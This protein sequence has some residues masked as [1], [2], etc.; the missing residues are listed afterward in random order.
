MLL[1]I[2]YRLS[3]LML[4]LF[5]AVTSVSI[6]ASEDAGQTVPAVTQD[7]QN[8]QASPNESADIS[9]RFE[10][11]DKIHFAP[12]PENPSLECGTINLPVDYRKPRGETFGMVVIR[13]KATNPAKRI[14][15]LMVN[16]GGPGG[17]GVNFII[18]RGVQLPLL[19]GLRE[20]FDLV[21]F[22]VRGSHRSRPVRCE[23]DTTNV[24]TDSSDEALATFFDDFGR[25]LAKA[26]LDQNGAFIT[27][28]STNNI[29]RDMDVL[30]RALGERQITYAGVSYG[31]ALGAVYA[32]LF[33]QRV[34]GMA[35]DGGML[36]EFRDYYAEYTSEQGVA[37]DLAFQRLDQ[38]CRKDSACRLQDTGVTPAFDTVMAQLK[39]APVTSK[40]GVVLS[41]ENATFAIHSLLYI[42][43]LW[44]LI[45][46]A[47]ANALAGNHTLF[48]QFASSVTSITPVFPASTSEASLAIQCNDF[49]TRRL[50][51]EYLP[52]SQAF[53]AYSPRF[54]G[55]PS[56]SVAAQLAQCS[57]W[58]AAD[59]PIIRNVK[60]RVATPIMLV[61]NDF[62][63]S[64]P[65]NWTRRLARALGMEQSLIRYQGG[66]HTA[67]AQFSPCINSALKAYLFDL[68]IPAEGF[69]CPAQPIR[70]NPPA[71]P[72]AAEGKLKTDTL[73]DHQPCVPPVDFD[74]TTGGGRVSVWTNA[75]TDRPPI[76]C[77]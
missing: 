5:V 44:P 52:V 28:M 21:S 2:Q 75:A 59:L 13:A 56:V 74:P 12:C 37:I 31:T 42:E 10:V 39:A 72:A 60:N 20:R 7:S 43:P 27:S 66:G 57:G 54:I 38:L 33:P 45:V 62:D 49:G 76:D 65:L 11:V 68:T 64:T 23:V 50:A 1:I 58:P 71:A 35:L 77:Q 40:D 41:D 36:P 61:G 25:R 69:S 32:S 3:A 48:F 30:R 22:D 14:G 16:P 19:I 73:K 15:V 8:N 6:Y 29:A 17:S 46:D 51:T 4:V 55:R 47:L 26:C 53:S 63:P 24:P 70:F 34:R 18:G 9:E 67:V